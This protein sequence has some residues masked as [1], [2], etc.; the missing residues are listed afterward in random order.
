MTWEEYAAAWSGLHGGFDPRGASP[1]VRGWIRLTYRAGCL[2]G[3]LGVG[4][5]AVTA[6]GLLLCLGVPAAALLGNAGLLLGA[7][8][9]LLAA[10]ADGLDGAVAV[11][12]GRTS[13]IGFVYDSVADRLGELAWLA[14]FWIAGAPGWLVVAAGA[15]SWLHEYVR[16]RAAAGGMRGLGRVTVGE[17]PTRVSVAISGL[18]IGG[19]AGLAHPGWET[20]VIIAAAVVWA[21]LG[22]AGL[23]QLMG[24]VRADRAG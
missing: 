17:R 2:L 21:G 5:T 11:V 13:R 18:L 20:A 10:G 14:A 22:L 15:V 6:F 1:V 19:L 23:V 8:L 9:V 24:A 12:T 3:R 7:A 16:A 4:P